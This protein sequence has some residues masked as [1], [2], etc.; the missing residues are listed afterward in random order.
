VELCK[1]AAH[2]AHPKRYI[3]LD[4]MLP[5]LEA[6]GRRRIEDT[7][8]E[9]RSQCPEVGELID[10]F[11]DEAEEYE[12]GELL[13]LIDNKI[14][15]HVNPKIV[16]VPGTVRARDVAAFL[17]Q[18]GVVFGRENLQDGSYRHL[19]YAERPSLLDSRTKLDAGLRW[20][21]HP[22]GMPPEI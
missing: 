10:G 1:V 5:Q 22:V 16:G 7:I 6:F 19:S 20:E 8:A 21:V 18:I 12:T 9:F 2:H 3:T 11:V 14:L 13:K 15:S 17:F 4:N